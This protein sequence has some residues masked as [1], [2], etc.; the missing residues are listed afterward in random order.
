[1]RPVAPEALSREEV[2]SVGSVV[3]SCVAPESGRGASCGIRK[4]TAADRRVGSLIPPAKRG[5]QGFWSTRDRGELHTV[6]RKYMPMY[7]AEFQFRYNNRHNP[8][9]FGAAIRGC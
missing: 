7:V 4:S 2:E 3:I 6:S 1:M 5:G 8:D 9:I